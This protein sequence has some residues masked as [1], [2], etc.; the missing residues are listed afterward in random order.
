MVERELSEPASDVVGSGRWPVPSLWRRFVALLVDWIAC[1]LVSGTFANPTTQ[2]WPPVLILIVEY[3]FFLGL[4][5]Q[6]LGMYLAR[7]RCVD[8]TRGG[9]IGVPRALWRGVLLALVVPAL[10]MDKDR[11]GIHDRL[12]NSVVTAR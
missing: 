2:G 4:F 8:F 12:T 6:T 1:V 9:P 7:L 3:G 11:R 5:G 10:I